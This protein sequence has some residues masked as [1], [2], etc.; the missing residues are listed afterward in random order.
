MWLIHT[1]ADRSAIVV[2]A[3][4]VPIKKFN[5][6]PIADVSCAA[7]CGRDAAVGNDYP[8]L[9]SPEYADSTFEGY[10]DDI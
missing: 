7:S 3:V 8:L 2:I 10:D 9:A 6:L 4:A 5:S 1:H